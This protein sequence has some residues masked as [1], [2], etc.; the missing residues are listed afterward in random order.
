[1]VRFDRRYELAD[2]LVFDAAHGV[3]RH[4]AVTA[5]AC[6]FSRRDT[7]NWMARSLCRSAKSSITPLRRHDLQRRMNSPQVANDA[8]GERGAWR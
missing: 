2:H 8:V 4:L 5:L 1:M 3:N 6:R 7:G